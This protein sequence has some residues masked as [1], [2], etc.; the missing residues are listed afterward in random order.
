M[1]RALVTGA[2]GAIGEA[3]ARQLADDGCHVIVH[4]NS[5]PDKA[6]QIVSDL[7]NKGLSSES[8]VFDVTDVR[9][10]SET[11]EKI[12]Q[13]GPIQIV[14]NNAGTTDDMLMAGMEQESWLNVIDVTLN[15]FFNVTKPLLLPMMRTRWGRVI[16]ISSISG[17]VGN[18]GQTNYSAA[19]AGLNGATKALA[20]E[21]ASRTVTVNAVAPGIIDT[22]M[23]NSHFSDDDIKKLVPMRRAGTAQEVANLVSFLASDRADY[24]SGQVIAINGALI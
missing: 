20:K 18:A 4:S 8:V 12:L 15:G 7:N 24:I 17:M 22:D 19:K 9:L 10:V 3:I 16:N 11:I 13:D 1:I 14:V 23:A 5:K 2:T 6:Q 21:V